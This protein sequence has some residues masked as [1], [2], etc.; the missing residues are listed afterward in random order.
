VAK[1]TLGGVIRDPRPQRTILRITG[2][3]MAPARDLSSIQRTQIHVRR[4]HAPA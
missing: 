4:Y 2:F 3:A 1:S